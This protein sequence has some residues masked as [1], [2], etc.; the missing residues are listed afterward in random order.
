MSFYRKLD[1]GKARSCLRD[2]GACGAAEPLSLGQWSLN[3]P[4]WWSPLGSVKNTDTDSIPD[5]LT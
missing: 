4:V 1:L 2:H 5:I 3:L